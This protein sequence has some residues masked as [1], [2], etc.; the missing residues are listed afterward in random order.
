VV[1][2]SGNEGENDMKRLR[3]HLL[4]IG[5][6]LLILSLI[7]GSVLDSLLISYPKPFGFK[8][9]TFLTVT[10]ILMFVVSMVSSWCVDLGNGFESEEFGTVMLKSIA[11]WA[12]NFIIFLIIDILFESLF[13]S[14]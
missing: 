11:G 14:G 4:W 2:Y 6:A 7:F 9:G 12:F 3:L 1:G 13:D 10:G 5:A 8:Y